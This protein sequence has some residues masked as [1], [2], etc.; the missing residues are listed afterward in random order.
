M[1]RKES[2]HGLIRQWQLQGVCLDCWHLGSHSPQNGEGSPTLIECDA[3]T[4]QQPGE[5][6]RSSADIDI[7]LWGQLPE[8]LFDPRGL[9]R[10]V[11]DFDLDA[12][13]G[14][15]VA[16]VGESRQ[17]P[18]YPA[19]VVVPQRPT[20]LNELLGGLIA[21]HLTERS[22]GLTASETDWC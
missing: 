19:V 22:H 9:R 11:P 6:A 2:R 15:V 12:A 5:G 16:G 4:W 8:V 7:G 18:S 3:R 14:P 21:D 10:D 1:G 20:M 13:A 17:A